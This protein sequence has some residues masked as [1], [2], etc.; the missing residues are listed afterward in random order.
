MGDN[1]NK[2]QALDNKNQKLESFKN[3]ITQ[4][5]KLQLDAPI[6]PTGNTGLILSV[7]ALF[8]SGKTFFLKHYEKTLESDEGVKTIYFD[9]WKVDNFD[10]LTGLIGQ[11][12]DSYNIKPYTWYKAL[13]VSICCKVLIKLSQL[14]LKL[15]SWKIH[16]IARLCSVDFLSIAKKLMKS[17][18]KAQAAGFGE[19]LNEYHKNKKIITSFQ[20]ELSI[21][22]GEKIIKVIM[23]D[24]LD[25]CRPDYAISLLEC[26]KHIFNTP[27]CVFIIAIDR[28][29]LCAMIKKRYG[30]ECDANH[31]LSRFFDGEFDL[32]ISDSFF[33]NLVGQSYKGIDLLF[34]T[35]PKMTAR[36]ALK[37]YHHQTIIKKINNTDY[38][39]R[40][41]I[42]L[43]TLKNLY[44]S[45][46]MNDYRDQ[47]LL[48]CLIKLIKKFGCLKYFLACSDNM[49]ADVLIKVMEY[50]Y[51]PVSVV[52]HEYHHGRRRDIYFEIGNTPIDKDDKDALCKSTKL[53]TNEIDKLKKFI[54][55]K[56]LR[57]LDKESPLRQRKFN[58]NSSILLLINSFITPN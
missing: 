28:K 34:N 11:I 14:I 27:N 12:C 5:I 26:C 33:F 42:P 50:F 3:H 47:Y 9:A 44:G 29:N 24:E 46:D 35:I 6:R 25:R 36:E 7:N 16:F 15:L 30:N 48:G 41:L 39:Y 1:N 54:T 10:P 21:L 19:K 57:H 58:I 23:V 32:P 31:Y 22:G 43:L 20:N 40:F 38:D 53:Q 52:I 56:I 18:K 13:W 49:Q 51:L 45:L 2:N 17:I 4:F 37:I 8:G 55:E